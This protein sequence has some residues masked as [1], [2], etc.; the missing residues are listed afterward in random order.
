M[1]L[2]PAGG[3]QDYLDSVLLWTAS[4]KNMPLLCYTVYTVYW[5]GY[6]SDVNIYF[7]M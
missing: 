1:M 2:H 3:R 7:H 4:G 5:I 6:Y